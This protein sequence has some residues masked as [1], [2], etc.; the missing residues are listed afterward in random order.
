MLLVNCASS[1]L[2]NGLP[3]GHSLTLRAAVLNS[4]GTN[5]AIT[6]AGINFNGGIVTVQWTTGLPPGTNYEIRVYDNTAQIA[7]YFVSL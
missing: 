7:Q 1:S 4:D 5:G 2:A 6:A 3:S